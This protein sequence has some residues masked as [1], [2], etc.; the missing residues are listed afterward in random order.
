MHTVSGQ[1]DG[2][3]GSSGTVSKANAAVPALLPAFCALLTYRWYLVHHFKHHDC[4][5]KSPRQRPTSQAAHTGPA[6]L[7]H[8]RHA[9]HASG[10]SSN[11]HPAPSALPPPPLA[12]PPP[13]PLLTRRLPFLRC[14]F[15]AAR[16]FGEQLQRSGLDQQL[17]DLLDIV[18]AGVF[19]QRALG[20][21]R[22]GRR[23]GL[24]RSPTP[25]PCPMPLPPHAPHR[26]SSTLPTP[27]AGPSLTTCSPS[28]R[29]PT[30]NGEGARLD[31]SRWLGKQA[32]RERAWPCS[33]SSSQASWLGQSSGMPIIV[34]PLNA[35]GTP[36]ATSGARGTTRAGSRRW[37]RWRRRCGSRGPLM[38]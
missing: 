16:I 3:V 32:S 8:L 28:S 17:E 14:A 5:P 27:P 23:R 21:G 30:T 6:L 11:P 19:L 31:G 7:P 12:D 35:G 38:A 22:H 33:P 9:A 29:G 18:R 37:R 10:T 13:P 25:A 1:P 24:E 20:L 36:A 26:P 15:F 4:S 2:R 34:L